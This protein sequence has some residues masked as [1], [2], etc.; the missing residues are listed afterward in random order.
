MIGFS[1]KKIKQKDDSII[2]R[3]KIISIFL[4]GS[5]GAVLLM[6]M[7]I[8]NGASEYAIKNAI[9]RSFEVTLVKAEM[10]F[11]DIHRVLDKNEFI[12]IVQELTDD[13]STLYAVVDHY[14]ETIRVGNNDLSLSFDQLQSGE[15]N[16]SGGYFE[17][18]GR[19]YIW[20]LIVIEDQLYPVLSV[21][22]FT[23]SQNDIMQLVFS[24][25]LIIPS[26][27]IIWLTVWGSLM[28]SRLLGRL[29][30]Q[31]VSLEAFVTLDPL[32]G[33]QNQKQARKIIEIELSKAHRQNQHLPVLLVLVEDYFEISEYYGQSFCDAIILTIS[34]RLNDTIRAYDQVLRYRKNV[35]M[36]LLPDENK[37]SSALVEKRV[38]KE[39]VQQYEIYGHY[40]Q[41]TLAIERVIYPDDIHQPDEFI[42]G[43]NSRIDNRVTGALDNSNQPITETQV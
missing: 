40:I 23:E 31:R 15:Q 33:L 35:F 19:T 14:P 16:L 8:Y 32:T 17:Q 25:R 13:E 2:S 24:N 27:F 28:L 41:P 21:T 11:S 5:L 30:E 39:L 6:L 20:N 1:V 29:H 12:D 7:A 38:Y 22:E 26:I 10:A 42:N 18:L 3:F 34:Q 43:C 36:V 37:E 9:Q 4:S